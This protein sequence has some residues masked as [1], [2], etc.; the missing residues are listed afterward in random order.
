VLAIALESQDV[1]ANVA[2]GELPIGD[3]GRSSYLPTDRGLWSLEY[4]IAM[5]R[6]NLLIRSR[7][8]EVTFDCTF[9]RAVTLSCRKNARLED[10]RL[11]G[12]AA[13]GKI[14]GYSFGV[15]GSTGLAS[16]TVTIGCAIGHA[17]L[18]LSEPGDPSYVEAGYVAAG[19]QAY[20]NTVSV[21]PESDVGYTVPVDAPA[22]DGLVFPLTRSAAIVGE[23]ISGSY[24]DQEAV[25]EAAFPYDV[26]VASTDILSADDQEVMA[27][28]SSLTVSEALKANPVSYH[29]ELR[30]VTGMSFET[31]FDVA[32]SDLRVPKMIDLEAASSP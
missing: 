13:L 17:G 7:A 10:D 19:Y 32:V 21:L 30:P 8:V 31:A 2:G 22:D 5:A 12:G 27:K 29:L 18:V 3:L 28:A 16:G 15:S 6:A 23:Y 1:G 25:I 24:Q 4:L 26:Y 14:I 20:N 11:P 9:A